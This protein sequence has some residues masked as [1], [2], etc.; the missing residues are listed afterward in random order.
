MATKFSAAEAQQTLKVASSVIR[1]QADELVVLRSKVA[2]MEQ[3]Q[4]SEKLAHRMHD[5]GIER[6]VPFERLVE[7][8]DKLAE[9]GKF[10]KYAEAVEL[11]GPDMGT[12]MALRGGSDERNELGSSDLV[13]WLHGQIG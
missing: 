1:A 11:V 12:T 3:R 10:D 2:S 7:N 5:K 4:R 13:R 9:M 6:D 8:L